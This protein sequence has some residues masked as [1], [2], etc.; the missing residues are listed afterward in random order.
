MNFLQ[1]MIILV[2]LINFYFTKGIIIAFKTPNATTMPS[3][4]HYNGIFLSSISP[5]SQIYNSSCTSDDQCSG[6]L[7][8]RCD[9][10]YCK[11]SREFTI[12]SSLDKCVSDYPTTTTRTIPDF[13]YQALYLLIFIISIL[14]IFTVMYF[15]IK[16]IKLSRQAQIQRN[17]RVNDQNR[18]PNNGNRRMNEIPFNSNESHFNRGYNTSINGSWI[19]LMRQSSLHAYEDVATIDGRQTAANV[20]S[21]ETAFASWSNYSPKDNHVIEDQPPLYEEAVANEQIDHTI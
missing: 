5:P 6:R 20:Y 16:S 9:S 8:G 15:C 18:D 14:G 10:G 17:Q 7:H 2:I 13:V 1:K 19:S 12:N 21:I 11:C 4:N 3:N